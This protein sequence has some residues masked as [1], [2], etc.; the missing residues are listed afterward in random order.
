VF[1]THNTYELR[2]IE[3]NIAVQTNLQRKEKYTIVRQKPI[4]DRKNYTSWNRNKPLITDKRAQ[5]QQLL[6]SQT[7]LI[8]STTPT[9]NTLLSTYS[10]CLFVLWFADTGHIYYREPRSWKGVYRCSHQGTELAKKEE[11]KTGKI[12]IDVYGR[13]YPKKGGNLVLRALKDHKP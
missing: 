7:T 3:V 11:E 12:Y 10:A 5:N 4:Y 8:H 2:G 1:Y 13:Y 9:P 6:G